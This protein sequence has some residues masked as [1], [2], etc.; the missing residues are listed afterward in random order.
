MEFKTKTTSWL[1]TYPNPND[2]IRIFCLP[3]AGSGASIYGQWH[4]FL[5]KD[6]GVYPIQLPGR[7]NRICEDPI[8][9]MDS[10]VKYIT[11]SI[12]PYLDKPFLFFGHSL[13]ARVA[14]EITHNLNS[15]YNKIPNC[16]IVSGSR[17]PHIPEPNPIHF[18][19]DNEFLNAIGKLSGIPN[20]I[21]EN[22]E[23]M[24]LFLPILR[25][26]YTID[27]TYVFKD[28]SPLPCPIIAFGGVYDTEASED[29]IQD[30]SAYTSNLFSY[31]MIEG[32]H[33]F[34]KSHVEELLNKI[35]KIISNYKVSS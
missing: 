18:L 23:L 22:K 4:K 12:L 33:F 21:F 16:L 1:L 15:V 5:P 29:E 27:E 6:I 19:P 24:N 34:F 20:I 2:K 26:D 9:D 8:L 11:N 7:E 17:A 13:G 32:D 35:S 3:C 28:K 14:F 25:A 31:S 10:L 30:W